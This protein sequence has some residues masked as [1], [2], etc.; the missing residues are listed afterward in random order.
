MKCFV[1]IVYHEHILRAY[2]HVIAYIFV[3]AVAGAT[4]TLF[5]RELVTALRLTYSKL[6][7]V[8]EKEIELKRLSAA[9]KKLVPFGLCKS[10]PINNKACTIFSTLQSS[11]L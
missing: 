1:N 6:P 5:L 7:H 10:K 8:H 11:F 3:R 9:L 2:A 4:F